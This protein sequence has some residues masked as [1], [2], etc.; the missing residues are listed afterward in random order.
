MWG[1]AIYYVGMTQWGF[2]CFG[3]FCSLPLNA[4]T[5][6]SVKLMLS[7]RKSEGVMGV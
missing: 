2:T 7:C 1:D 4:Y 6:M 3:K 5:G